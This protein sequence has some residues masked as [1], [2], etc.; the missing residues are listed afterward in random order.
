MATSEVDNLKP[1]PKLQA[2]LFTKHEEMALWTPCDF[3]HEFFLKHI[4]CVQDDQV[5][6]DAAEVQ[7]AAKREQDTTCNEKE[8]K[9]FSNA[10]HHQSRLLPL[11]HATFT[12]HPNPQYCTHCFIIMCVGSVVTSDK[13]MQLCLET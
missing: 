5:A 8:C 3:P 9:C 13:K 4:T 10:K 12:T 2:A 6:K 7:A 11:T 1:H